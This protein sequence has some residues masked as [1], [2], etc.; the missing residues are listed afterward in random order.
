MD[1]SPAYDANA[2]NKLHQQAA[3]Q[4]PQALKAVAKQV[5]GLFVQMMLKSMRDALPQEGL[6]DNHQTQLY[7]SLYDQQI[8][9]QL[10]AKGLGLADMM[11]KQLSPAQGAAGAQDTTSA[12]QGGLPSMAPGTGTFMPPALLGEMLRR[13]MPQQEGE[14][15]AAAPAAT[16]G[17]SFTERLAIPAMIAGARSGISHHLILA[18]AALESGWGKREIPTADGKPSHNV[19]GIKATPDWQGASTTVMTTEYE[20]GRAVKVPQRFKVYDSYLSAIEDYIS[21]LTTNPRYREVVNARQPEEGAY[22][23]QRAGYATDPGYGEKL[24]QI[25]GQL[26]DTAHRAVKAYTHDLSSLF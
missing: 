3:A 4:S 2:L 25:I 9:Q 17:G 22:A 15:Q 16:G 18:Q 24:V 8:A 7:T 5:E 11:V 19:F 20:N 6:L 14:S 1:L 12:A 21:L 10:S 23:L 13:A 26:K